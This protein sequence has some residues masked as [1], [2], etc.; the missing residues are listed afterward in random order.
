LSLESI[1]RELSEKDCDLLFGALDLKKAYENEDLLLRQ[2]A[3]QKLMPHLGE[4]DVFQQVYAEYKGWTRVHLPRAATE[5]LK[6]ARFVLWFSPRF[7]FTPALYCPNVRT[8]IFVRGLLTLSRCPHCGTPFTPIKGNQI[9][10]TESC[11]HAHRTAKWRFLNQLK[12]RRRAKKR[13][14]RGAA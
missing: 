5:A 9:H 6:D 10:C 8:G 12:P 13:S 2:R 7:G 1:Q 4:P 11:G 3:Y 14:K